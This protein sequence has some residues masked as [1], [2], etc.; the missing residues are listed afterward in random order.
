MSIHKETFDKTFMIIS[1]IFFVAF[2]IIVGVL[3]YYTTT[4]TQSNI[5]YTAFPQP[6]PK[7]LTYA[8]NYGA[9]DNGISHIVKNKILPDGKYLTTQNSCLSVDPQIQ[10]KNTWEKDKCI[11]KDG[12]Y[13]GYCDLNLYDSKYTAIGNINDNKITADKIKILQTDKISFSN[14][15]ET[16]CSNFCSENTKCTGFYFNNNKCILYNGII[17][18]DDTADIT[19]TNEIKH[20]LYVKSLDNLLF[21]NIIY[22]YKNPMSLPVRHWI[23]KKNRNF[24]KITPYKV[25]TID[26]KPNYIIYNSKYIG[27]YS[28]YPF[29]I[30]D[31]ETFHIDTN[32]G[33]SYIHMPKYDFMI[34]DS[35]ELFDKLYVLYTNIDI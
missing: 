2:I 26:F 20:T 30:S 23:F 1:V 17:T 29:N 16:S 25:T 18:I 4:L 34:P 32:S 22:L 28:P 21:P 8:D 15:S 12:K 35:W 11:C 10:N 7:P 9:S 31:I 24:A 6:P 19:Y 14:Q 33:Y 3:I 27:Y 13:G 5:T